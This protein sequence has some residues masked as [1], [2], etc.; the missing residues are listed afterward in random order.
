MSTMS[1]TV[2]IGKITGIDYDNAWVTVECENVPNH[3]RYHSLRIGEFNGRSLPF[4]KG[5][6]VLLQYVNF[7]THALWCPIKVY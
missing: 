3:L 2:L 6:A 1:E 4:D 5:R 7:S